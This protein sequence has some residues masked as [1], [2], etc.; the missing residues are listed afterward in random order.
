MYNFLY[1]QGKKVRE[2]GHV[3]GRVGGNRMKLAWECDLSLLCL[4]PWDGYSREGISW[5]FSMTVQG[6]RDS[7]T[8]RAKISWTRNRMGEFCKEEDQWERRV[9]QIALIITQLLLLLLKKTVWQV[10]LN[11]EHSGKTKEANKQAKNGWRIFP[12]KGAKREGEKEMLYLC[13][14]M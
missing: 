6:C 9:S 3:L 1:A 14:S 11:S 4:W 12:E 7:L 2:S 8:R 13:C 10:K 5:K